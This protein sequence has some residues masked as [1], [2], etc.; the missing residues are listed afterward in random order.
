MKKRELSWWI[1]AIASVFACYFLSRF[2][3]TRTLPPFNDEFI[4]VRWAQEGFFDPAKRLVSLY[5]GKQPFYIWLVT[6]M[7]QII[8]S[9]MAAGRIVS[10]LAGAGTTFGLIF[11][12]W[13]L[14]RDRL[15]ALIAGF[16]YVLFP[17]ALLLDRFALYDG[18]LACLTVWSLNI[19]L[20]LIRTPSLGAALGLALVLG[21]AF[22]TKSSA[23]LL[24]IPL[25]LAILF[26]E[27]NTTKRLRI[28]GY[29][30][31]AGLMAWVY[32][33]V[34]V[35]SPASSFV[36]TKNTTFIYTFKELQRTSVFSVIF[37]NLIQYSELLA[38]YLS[39]FIF[40]VIANLFFAKNQ[41]RR[42]LAYLILAFLVPFAVVV[43]VGKLIYSRHLYFLT[44]P[45]LMLVAMGLASIW[46]KMKILNHK[47]LLIAVSVLPVL[48]MDARMILDFKTTPL[49]KSDKFQYVEGWP[50][51][52]GIKEVT[53]FIESKASEGELT[54]LTEGVFGSLPTTAMEL[55]FGNYPQVHIVPVDNGKNM[56]PAK[57]IDWQ[58]PVYLILSKKQ[59]LPDRFVGQQ[60]LKV[61][62]GNGDSYLQLYKLSGGR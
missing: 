56:D 60:I 57:I 20:L 22:L 45:L 52:W 13:Q 3:A 39:S 40:A 25:F 12:S 21:A 61:Q 59:G 10:I 16:V 35:L 26:F 32:Q 7:M 33:S 48:Y 46:T 34:Q 14:F 1:V 36:S 50:A 28:L 29:F 47:L 49:P 8:P 24:V 55:Y 18:L 31:I 17:L 53:K 42:T 51:G 44:M 5:D 19:M 43:V 38:V 15:V 30:A 58:H 4:Y 23:I 11:L 54:L 62:R 2:I 6:L 9:P 27:K 37:H 41:A